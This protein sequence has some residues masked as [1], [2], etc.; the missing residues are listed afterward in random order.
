[1]IT[2]FYNV[3][4]SLEIK[5]KIQKKIIHS[6]SFA[7]LSTFNF[8]YNFCFKFWGRKADQRYIRSL[9]TSGAG[10][11]VQGARDYLL[12]RNS[13]ACIVFY[14]CHYYSSLFRVYQHFSCSLPLAPCPC[15]RKL[16]AVR[17]THVEL[18]EAPSAPFSGSKQVVWRLHSTTIHIHIN[19][20]VFKEIFPAYVYAHRYAGGFS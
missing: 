17:P 20:L 10:G 19:T 9:R 8:Q 4:A 2:V 1:M 3:V 11:K 5:A 16:L 14:C 13:V 6:H 12:H 15:F 7:S 18:L